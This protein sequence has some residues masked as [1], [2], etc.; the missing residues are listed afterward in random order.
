MAA[1]ER[2]LVAGAGPVGLVAAAH[3]ARGGV[4]VTV[5][6]EGPGLSE[7]SRASTFHPPT[8]DMLHDLGA[9]E[10]MIAQGLIAP[11]F[12]YRSKKR[13]LLAQFDFAAIA[14][15]T[16]HPYRVQCEQ[17][18]LT[19][20]LYEQMRNHPIFRIDRAAIVGIENGVV[21]VVGFRTAVFVFEA[22]DV[23]F[24]V[25]TLVFAVL[26]AIAIV[27]VFRATVAILKVVK[28]LGNEWTLVAHVRN[29]VPI[30]I[31]QIGCIAH[32]DHESKPR[33]PDAANDADAASGQNT[34]AIGRLGS[35]ASANF[36]RAGIEFDRRERRASK[37][38]RNQ[39]EI[40]GDVIGG[41]APVGELL[42]NFRSVDL[43]RLAQEH[44]DV[45][46]KS[47]Q[48]AGGIQVSC[49]AA[50]R[51]RQI[52]A[53][54]VVAS[55][56]KARGN[57][58][59][60]HPGRIHRSAANQS[61]LGLDAQVAQAGGLQATR[62]HIAGAGVQAIALHGEDQ[63]ERDTQVQAFGQAIGAGELAGKNRGHHVGARI[64][65]FVLTFVDVVDDKRVGQIRHKKV[66]AVLTF[67]LGGA[68]ADTHEGARAR[69]HIEELHIYRGV[70]RWRRLSRSVA[71]SESQ[72]RGH[73]GP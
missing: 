69:G 70:K 72:H 55:G 34:E 63:R 32:G 50:S 25:R 48:P 33:G 38:L 61:A 39:R 14:D 53:Q 43:S 46:A 4:P 56:A 28:V 15:V 67:L 66:E 13:G 52:I 40:V 60:H 59:A 7:E 54:V 36:E 16:A 3:L 31:A 6:E 23:L 41:S 11:A 1:T 71:E 9:A 49:Q 65:N 30:G 22:V 2:I 27:V 8:L 45:G 57:R 24:V 21:V 37:G 44:A 62:R 64:D 68:V 12:Q 35:H 73:N 29:A 26:A 18:K 17:S 5:F 42:A 47:Q 58:E 20:I 19:R 10:P 51:R